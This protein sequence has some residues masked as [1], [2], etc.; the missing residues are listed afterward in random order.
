MAI[1]FYVSNES[2]GIFIL[3]C[4]QDGMY[5]IRKSS[6]GGDR[7]YVLVVYYEHKIYNLP[8]RRRSDNKYA[9]GAEKQGEHVSIIP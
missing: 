7:P 9:L 3:F 4:S 5:C 8:V 1:F 6:R 2:R